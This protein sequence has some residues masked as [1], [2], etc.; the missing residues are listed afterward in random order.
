MNH[1]NQ[2]INESVNKW[3]SQILCISMGSN[4]EGPE[5]FSDPESDN[6]FLKVSLYTNFHADTLLR[7]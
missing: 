2:S 4:L 6:K 1:F 7:F 5:K 3:I